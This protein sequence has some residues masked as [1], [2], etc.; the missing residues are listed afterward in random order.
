MVWE[1]QTIASMASDLL[2]VYDTVWKTSGKKTP[3]QTK[4]KQ[5]K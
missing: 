3:E 2:E 5:E 1:I 4:N